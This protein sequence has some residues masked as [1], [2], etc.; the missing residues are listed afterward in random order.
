MHFSLELGMFL[1]EATSSTLGDK[2][3]SLLMFKSLKL[4]S[5]VSY[6]ITAYKH[7]L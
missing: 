7:C 3:I 1:E 5:L 6:L 4:Y 2:T